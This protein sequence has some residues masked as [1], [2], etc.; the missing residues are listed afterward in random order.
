M[1]LL[2]ALE[3]SLEDCNREGYRHTMLEEIIGE[4]I[5]KTRITSMR[6]REFTKQ[7]WSIL[8]CSG[9]NGDINSNNRS[10]DSNDCSGDGFSKEECE[11]LGYNSNNK[12][13]HYAYSNS[14]SD[15]G[16][17]GSHSSNSTN[18]SFNS[19]PRRQL[20]RLEPTK[21]QIL[22]MAH[23]EISYREKR[24]HTINIEEHGH[25]NGGEGLGDHIVRLCSKLSK[26]H[27]AFLEDQYELPRGNRGRTR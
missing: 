8:S 17:E 11:Y 10:D 1:T 7:Q 12:S 24:T 22:I 19:K 14:G 4:L 26:D 18:R 15:S 16:S 5:T 6:I 27:I 25:A 21:N 2:N 23:V 20:P 9:K 3:E 13:N